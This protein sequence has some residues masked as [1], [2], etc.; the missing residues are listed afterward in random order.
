[1]YKHNP[2]IQFVFEP[3]TIQKFLKKSSYK[4]YTKSTCNSPP[5]NKNYFY[6]TI[7]I[8]YYTQTKGVVYTD[9]VNMFFELQ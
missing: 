5:I 8:S 6:N 1:M 7:K 2:V 9:T 4:V 3:N